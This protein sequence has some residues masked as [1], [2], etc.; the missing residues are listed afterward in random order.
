MGENQAIESDIDDAVAIYDKDATVVWKAL[1]CLAEDEYFS[2]NTDGKLWNRAV[3]LA[4]DGKYWMRPAVS[5]DLVLY[6]A[7]LNH[8]KHR[9]ALDTYTYLRGAG[10]LLEAQV[11]GD[12][13][14]KEEI[15]RMT[16]IRK[17]YTKPRKSSGDGA[18]KIQRTLRYVLALL[19]VILLAVSLGGNGA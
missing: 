12:A 1:K 9:A 3:D 16:E 4:T 5:K 14:L 8:P 13:R 10:I 19:A 7:I 18:N 11:Y 6:T 15:Q 17:M 2:G